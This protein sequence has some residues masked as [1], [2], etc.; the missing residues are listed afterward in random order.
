[1]Q[2]QSSIDERRNFEVREFETANF[3]TAN[4]GIANFRFAPR[5]RSAVKQI[6]I[7]AEQ[8]RREVPGGI[9]T[10]ADGLLRG[11]GAFTS[12]AP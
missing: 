2:M 7:V 4:F 5:T 10:Y 3:E 12:E 9:G 11:L 6:A 8:L 1:M